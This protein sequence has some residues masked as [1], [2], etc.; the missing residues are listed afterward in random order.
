MSK[1]RTVHLR[2]VRPKRR[3]REAPELGGKV[4]EVFTLCGKW[5]SKRD[6]VRADRSLTVATCD[7]CR[8]QHDISGVFGEGEDE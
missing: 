4:N 3:A 5:V 1:R 7:E 6:A 2:K 8:A